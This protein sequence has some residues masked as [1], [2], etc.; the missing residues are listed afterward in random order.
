MTLSWM[1]CQS[2]CSFQARTQGKQEWVVDYR[3]LADFIER[4]PIAHTLR[5]M[6]IY[7]HAS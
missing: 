6:Y 4:N 7:K 5:N 1:I 3:L 2:V